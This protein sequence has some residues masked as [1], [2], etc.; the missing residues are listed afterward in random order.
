MLVRTTPVQKKPSFK[1]DCKSFALKI[2]VSSEDLEMYLWV[3]VPPA[4]QPSTRFFGREGPTAD[5]LKQQYTDLFFA[6]K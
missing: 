5:A 6:R 2:C 1:T 3:G 4:N